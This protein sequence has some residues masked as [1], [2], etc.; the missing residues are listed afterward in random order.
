MKAAVISDSHDNT[1]N[2][3]KAVEISNKKNCSYLF[4]LGDIIAPFSA[5]KLETFNGVVK[6]VFGNCDGERVG[7]LKAFNTI[8]GEIK[9][10]PFELEIKNKKILLMHEP[11]LI[12]EIVH[13]GEVDYIFYG[14]LHKIDQRIENNTHILNPGETGGWVEKPTF[15]IVDLLS[16]QFEKIEL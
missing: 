3:S 8:G 9:K 12:N 15:F 7:L 6:A 14:H 4:H 1:N 16:N 2:I 10:P 5:L 11:Y 13:S